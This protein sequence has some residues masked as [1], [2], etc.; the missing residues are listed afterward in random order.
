MS[1]GI[2]DEDTIIGLLGGEVGQ[3]FIGFLKTNVDIDEL[4]NKPEMFP[5]L[6]RDSQY[7]AAI[8]LANWITMHKKAGEKA[9]PL[10]N[11]MCKV[12]HE[13]LVLT[14]MSLKRNER[15]EFFKLLFSHDSKFGSIISKVVELKKDLQH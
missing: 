11:A 6:D 12:S 9:L 4:I 2:E 14:S 8:L 1:R 15:V 10:I 3:L 7:I 5:T 13:F